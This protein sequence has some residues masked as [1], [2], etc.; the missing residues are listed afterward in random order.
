MADINN[1]NDRL[2]SLGLKV[3]EQSPDKGDE[4]GQSEFFNLMIAQLNNQDPLEPL[5]SSAFLT[6]VAQFSQLAGIQDMSRSVDLLA[7][8]LQSSQALQA[9][10]LV[11]RAVSVSGNRLLLDQAGDSASGAVLLPA[12]SGDTRLTITDPAGAAVRTLA[13]GALGA[14]EARFRWD[15]RDDQGQPAPAGYYSIRAEGVL[16]GAA[17]ALE[18]LVDSRVESVTLE[19]NAGGM[20][21]NLRDVGAVSLDD[22]HEIF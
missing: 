15:G 10:T 5:D 17:V 4:L 14:G 2:L 12:T 16:D 22:V 20:T 3:P 11:G 7:S 13:L 9:S 6:Q 19:R 21:L 8:S 18:T 1:V